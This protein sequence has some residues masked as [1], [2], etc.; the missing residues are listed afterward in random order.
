MCRHVLF[1]RRQLLRQRRLGRRW[2]DDMEVDA[3]PTR[4]VVSIDPL[5]FAAQQFIEGVIWQTLQHERLHSVN[6][7]GLRILFPCVLAG[8]CTNRGAVHRATR[9]AAKS[10]GRLGGYRCHGQ[11]MAARAELG[12]WCHLEPGR[13]THGIRDPAPVRRPEHGV[14]RPCD[15]CQ[16][17][18]FKPSHGQAFW[19]PD[20]A[21][22]CRRLCVLH[23]VVRVGVV[24]FRR[25]AKRRCAAAL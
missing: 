13:S 14:L 9:T 6:D 5:L 15:R 20:A 12:P 2:N 25:S 1:C 8:L 16:P 18:A 19:D 3:E 22:L 11:W 7:I 24:L 21:V 10:T 17:V 23:E 4:A